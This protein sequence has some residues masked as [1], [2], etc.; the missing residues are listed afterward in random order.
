MKELLQSDE[1]RRRQYEPAKWLD[2]NGLRTCV[3]VSGYK[4][5]DRNIDRLNH[6]R[7]KITFTI[8]D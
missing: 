5:K 7:L 4:N 8:N 2:G 3:W 6:S 1:S